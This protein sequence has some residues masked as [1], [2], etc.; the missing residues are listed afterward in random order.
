M[1]VQKWVPDYY[2]VARFDCPILE[3]K[4]TM[5]LLTRI[6]NPQPLDWSREKR[7]AGA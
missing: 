1:P 6:F 4:A 5:E 3:M 7:C 2:F